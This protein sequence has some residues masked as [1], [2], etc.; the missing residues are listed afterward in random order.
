MATTVEDTGKLPSKAQ[1]ETLNATLQ[2]INT[3]LATKFATK[4]DVT[5]NT[6]D[7]TTNKANIKTNTE[8]IAT[9]GTNVATNTSDIATN[10]SN[11]ETNTHDITVLTKSKLD[12]FNNAGFH[13]ANPRCKNLGTSITDAQHTA[14]QNQTYDDLFIGDY[15]TL[16]FN[17]NGTS[18][19]IIFR[20]WGC[21]WYLNY[22][23]TALTKGNLLIMPDPNIWQGAVMNSTNTTNGAIIGSAMY[24]NTIPAINTALA[25]T[26]GSSHLLTHRMLLPNATSN[27]IVS[28]CSWYDTQAML[29]TEEEIYGTREWSQAVQN[30]FDG[31]VSYNQFPLARFMPQFICNRATW[32]LRSVGG[33]SAFCFVDYGG[34]CRRADASNSVLG[35]RPCF[36]ID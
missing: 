27:G 23:D 31:N 24:K 34:G 9:L 36:L 29:P 19:N 20:I 26:F 35:V 33:A 8:D 4:D 30:G 6:N 18:K 16:P 1:M 2:S 3:N 15:W 32:W 22:G 25:T 17:D 28:N 10:K 7:I 21:G 11:I 5:T 12:I 13:N 14:I